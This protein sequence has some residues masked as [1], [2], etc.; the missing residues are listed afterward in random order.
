VAGVVIC[1]GVAVIAVVSGIAGIMFSMITITCCG[2]PG[3]LTTSC[4]KAFKPAY[5]LVRGMFGSR[6]AT[7]SHILSFNAYN[8]E[9]RFRI[10]FTVFS[11]RP[12]G[13]VV[14]I[15]YKLYLMVCLSEDLP[16]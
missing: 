8:I 4:R 13:T 12:R 6:C 3:I 1:A 10:C 2:T 14:R 16:V 11:S 9:A 5:T 7:T 15:K